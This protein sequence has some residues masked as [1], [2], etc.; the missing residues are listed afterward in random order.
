[1]QRCRRIM[2]ASTVGPVTLASTISTFLP[3]GLHWLAG[4]GA[5]VGVLLGVRVS[6]RAMEHAIRRA[7]ERAAEI[8]TN[9]LIRLAR[10][11]APQRPAQERRSHLAAD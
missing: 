9:E 7:E 10:A 3:D 6:L 2:I 11:S 1:M 4:P 8:A 5:I